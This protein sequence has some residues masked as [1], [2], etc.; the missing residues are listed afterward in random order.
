MSRLEQITPAPKMAVGL[1]LDGTSHRVPDKGKP[2]ACAEWKGQGDKQTDVPGEKL[3][4]ELF[5]HTPCAL[6]LDEFQ[7]WFDGLSKRLA[8]LEAAVLHQK[9]PR[10]SSTVPARITVSRNHVLSPSPS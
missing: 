1:A 10:P 2:S 5:K 6:I 9:H 8:V 4:L 7:T 3:L